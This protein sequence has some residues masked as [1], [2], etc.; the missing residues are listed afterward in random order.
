MKPALYRPLESAADLPRLEAKLRRSRSRFARLFKAWLVVSA[1]LILLGV[2]V[3]PDPNDP[4]AR[5]A[6]LLLTLLTGS[7]VA[8]RAARALGANPRVLAAQRELLRQRGHSVCPPPGE[9]ATCPP[10]G[11]PATCPPPGEPALDPDSALDLGRSDAALRDRIDASADRLRR[12]IAALS[13]QRRQLK[14]A[15]DRTVEA[16]EDRF[17]DLARAV[18]D[19]ARARTGR[20]AE[21]PDAG[22]ARRVD[23]LRTALE[24]YRLALADL[25][26][27]T[28]M[29]PELL[30][31]EGPAALAAARELLSP[32]PRASLERSGEG[33]R[34]DVAPKG[35]RRDS[36]RRRPVD[37]EAYHL[38]LKG[39]FFW[40]KRTPEAL[41][42][43]LELF[44]QAIARD[45]DHAPAHAGVA[46]A[47]NVLGYY[48][49]RAPAES[50][51]R[52]KEAAAK[53][54]ELDRDLAEGHCSLAF[55]RL[56]YDW[57]WPGAERAFLRAFEL[58][59]GYA[60]GHHWYAEYLSFRGRHQEAIAQ[61]KIAVELDPV[62]RILR[63]ILAWAYFYARRYQEAIAELEEAL[64]LEPGFA[65]AR[66]WLALACEQTG[67]LERAR[68]T[69]ERTAEHVGRGT[70]TR[71][72][73]G[74][75]YGSLGRGEEARLILAELEQDRRH[76]YV[77]AYYVAAVHAG[78]G[79]RQQA[80]AEL[81]RA[82][83]AR[84]NWLVMLAIDPVWDEL[85]AEP[86]FEALVREVGLA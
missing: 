32:E 68:R 80:L 48:S 59:P 69:L 17:D 39:R 60:T 58:D 77:S 64:R 25:E 54:L 11:E 66:F 63:T 55:A 52:A 45:P 26:L 43:S 8:T 42:E 3:A 51:P 75:L 78:L 38:V 16:A 37:A 2:T 6:P 5:F 29:D 14:D 85:R 67:E 18:V 83:E 41:E 40:N 19:L 34:R 81:E 31:R 10:P 4:G 46:D 50:F 35:H 70:L 47:L 44:G 27:G 7:W 74:R 53:A 12:G 15:L 84:D 79:D 49:L 20:P 72:V 76:K 23:G 62:S 82:A 28:L 86:R 33:H 21:A 13:V 24:S 36:A 30:E 71:A 1:L 22:E 73:L 57:D 61:A 9:P 56:L 65:P